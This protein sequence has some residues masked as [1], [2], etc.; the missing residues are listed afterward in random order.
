MSVK[1]TE[2]SPSVRLPRRAFTRILG[3]GAIALVS[4][5]P[6]AAGQAARSDSTTAKGPDPSDEI[7]FMS[8]TRLAR[9]IREK[10]LSAV[11][12]VQAYM[13]RI[14]AVN[15]K[16]N[17]V[18]QTCFDRALK[19]AKEADA[20]ASGGRFKGPLHGV[21]M[22]IKDSIDTEGVISTGGTVGRMNYV[23]KKDATV[24]ARLRAAGAILLGKT[25][26]PEFTLAGGGISGVVSTA[27]IIYGVSRN[28]YDLTRSTAGS[29]GGAGAIVAAG[30]AAFDVGSDWG[31]SIRGPAHN[32]GIAGIKPTSGRVPRTGHIVDFGGV[33]D[34]WQQLGPMAR[35]VEDL[36]LIMPLIVGPDFRDAAIAPVPWNDPA[37]VEVSGLRVAFYPE[38]GVAE[39]TP[40]TKDTVRRAA[41]F[42]EEA[43][44]PVK[45]DLPKSILMEMEEVRFKLPRADA[46][47]GLKRLG[48]KW[49]T[50]SLSPTIVERLKLE[51]VTAPEYTELLEMQDELRSK[52]LA[53]VRNYDVVL[54]PVGGK[55]ALP[56]DF[57]SDG[58]PTGPGR[59]YTGLYNS[60]GWPAAVVRAGTSPE[61]LPI[62]VQVIGQP[63]RDDVVLAVCGYL[64]SKT[65]GWQKPPI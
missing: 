18:V 26:T 22:T 31:G 23:P 47:S 49:G 37:K 58:P 54:C 27:N 8:T 20:L 25:N 50:K 11:E 21:P 32:N 7:I 16:L 33:F 36:C 60:T 19:E 10:K 41:K 12:A 48:D 34:S 42:L 40:E 35:R 3:S 43:G 30:G 39:T 24:V 38:N 44:C 61:G 28:P 17:A 53:W 59:S 15:P 51:Q 57:G 2:S 65:G 46:W 1:E 63:W 45:E 14:T 55:P 6:G 64:E 29:S 13:A 56:I 9:M 5:A 52:L 62:G 4:R